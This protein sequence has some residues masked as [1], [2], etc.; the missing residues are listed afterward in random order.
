MGGEKEGEDLVMV[1]EKISI[2]IQEGR[3]K[4]GF[5]QSPL[6]P[7]FLQRTL[8]NEYAAAEQEKEGVQT[9]PKLCLMY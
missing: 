5:K 1:L 3:S 9:F 4:L 8:W 6:R 7:W 2:H